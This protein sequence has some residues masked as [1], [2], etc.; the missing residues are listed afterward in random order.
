MAYTAACLYGLG[1]LGGILERVLPGSMGFSVV[2]SVVAVALAAALVLAGARLP[3][4][5]L[6]PLG[7]IGVAFVA[8]AVGLSPNA[9]DGAALFVLPVLWMSFFFRGRG[10]LVI[11]LCV[12]VAYALLL[13][14]LPASGGS[15]DRWMDVMIAVGA[16]SA[17]ITE[18]ARRDDE[19]LARVAAE[20]RTDTLTGLLNRRGFDERATVE[21]AHARRE[22]SSIALASFDLDYFK[23]VNDE[24]GHDAGDRVLARFGALLAQCSREVDAVARV[25][26]EE[27]AVLLPGADGDAAAAF[28]ERIRGEFAVALRADAL[29][30]T[31]V[32]A[33]VAVAAVPDTIERLLR[34]ADAALYAAKRAGRGRTVVDAGASA[35]G[36]DRI[37]AR[38]G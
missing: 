24:W 22:G 26:G 23:R 21:L 29:P 31:G 2:P 3:R 20:A 35:P 28:S 8:T 10:A 16:V 19:L 36:T 14:A 4:L 17:V 30:P 1:G 37:G 13:A 9:G 38:V 11:V 34:Q 12:G 6:A 25:G 18:L 15:S 33:G 27:F 5:A 7:P 32:S